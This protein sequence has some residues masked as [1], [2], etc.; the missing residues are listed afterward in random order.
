MEL[1]GFNI[2]RNK[3]TSVPSIVSPGTDDGSIV[4]IGNSAAYYSQ[5]MD[6][7]GV[8]KNE[9]DLIRRYREIS[10]YPDCDSAIED[11]INEAIVVDEA[12]Q[13]VDII[14]DDLKW[15]EDRN[16]IGGII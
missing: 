13:S 7:E 16:I 1:F 3:N 9:N 8:V 15:L 14:L 2:T 11:I 4:T 5:V 10:Q 12:D 6:L